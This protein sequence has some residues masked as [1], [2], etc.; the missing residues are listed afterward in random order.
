MWPVE[1]PETT[2][3]FRGEN[4][5][6]DSSSVMILKDQSKKAAT[7]THKTLEFVG[8]FHPPDLFGLL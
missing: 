1:H 7:Y 8:H 5:Y 6:T 2:A 3:S 4:V